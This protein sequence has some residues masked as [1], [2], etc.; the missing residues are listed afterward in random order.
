MIEN[1]GPAASG[2]PANAA[3][4]V[5]DR[6]YVVTLGLQPALL[7]EY[8]PARRVVTGTHVVPTGL[9]C[10]A[11]AA[12]GT[13]LYIG[14]WGTRAGER[15]L[16]RFDTTRGTFD[17]SRPVD[18]DYS[19]MTVGPDGRVVYLG[20]A[21][22]GLVYVWDRGSGAVSELAFDDPTG[23]E[24][25]TL[26]ATAHTLYVGL[27]RKQAGLVAID[28]S[29]GAARHILPRELAGGVGVY[30]LR[31]SGEVIAAATQDEPARLG[32]L[33]RD[34][35]S[36]Y[37]IVEPGGEHAIGAL[38]FTGQVVYFSG[39]GSGTLYAYDQARRQLTALA[40][41][42][43]AAPTRRT[44]RLGRALVGVTSPG[45]VFAYDLDTGQV[46]RTELTSAGA[47]GGVERPQSLAAAGEHVVVGTNNAAEIHSGGRTRRVVVSG[48][49]K[50]AT[51]VG[52]S[53]YVATY[54][55]GQLWRVPADGPG[56]PERVAN[57]PDVYDRPRAI[58][59]DAAAGLLLI[60]AN[61]DF[62]GGG[63]LV[64]TDEQGA[65]LHVHGD[66]LREG[67]EPNAVA[68][69]DGAAL[70]G[71]TADD[72]RLA[73]LDP[74]TG[75]RLWETVPVPGGGRITGLAARD[76][77]IYGLTRDAT[78]FRLDA[79]TRRVTRTVTLAQ[80]RTG[81]LVVHGDAVYAVDGQRLVKCHLRTLF[82][83]PLVTDITHI[84]FTP[85]P[86]L[87][88]DARGRLLLFSG[89]DL[90][91]VTDPHAPPL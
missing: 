78:L 87:R 67:Q 4:W 31:V 13:D 50:T 20:T 73:A 5:G 74:R 69:L 81:E 91:R 28:R 36:D 32:L 71:G 80:G 19:S 37:E 49:A 55:S 41:P 89:T 60:V 52:T 48:E 17:G 44:R 23:S 6:L 40:T 33:D 27:G 11:M 70:V 47:E 85:N 2:F 38:A 86:P 51:A 54:P 64:V 15:N 45:I 90:L 8:D 53:A 14:M 46:T 25:T 84:A 29:S 43:P 35:P 56:Q 65:L 12:V 66:P 76:G 79:A 21:R 72:A 77:A 75:R 39:I 26:A 58:H 9:R 88:L 63:A 83:T 1:L 10:W 59:H 18:A 61:A 22:T 3:E 7:A 57:W 82:P 34:D 62:V 30:N 16:Y 24:V 42:V 68:S